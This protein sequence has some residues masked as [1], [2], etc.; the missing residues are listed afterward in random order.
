[1]SIQAYQQTA[2][3][4]ESPREIE[5]R[6]FAQV[7]AG[8][9]QVRDPKDHATQI[10]R[11]AEA[12]DKNRRLW[13]WLAEDCAEPGNQLPNAMKAQI[14]SLAIFVDK[15]SRGVLQGVAD[16]DTL[17]DINRSIMEGLALQ[18]AGPGR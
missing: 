10:G 4:S 13:R 18:S 3:R 8:L 5:Y 14:I 6:V 12:L 9:A 15:H 16:I 1:M 11:V 2:Q 7:T 17:I